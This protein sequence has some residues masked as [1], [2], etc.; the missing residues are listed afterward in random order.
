MSSKKKVTALFDDI[1][2]N[3]LQFF[4]GWDTSVPHEG[5][6]GGIRERRVRD[7][8]ACHLPDKYGIGSGHIVDKKGTMSLQ[9]DIVIFDRINGPV[10]R[11]D[12]YYQVFPCESVCATVEVKST[13]TSGEIEKCIEH[14][15]RLE[16]LDRIDHRGDLG[17]IQSFVF[18]YDSYDNA[19]KAPSVW[20]RDKFQEIASSGPTPRPVPRAIL[21]LR[22]HFVLR[23]DV[24]GL[25][26]FS[27]ESGALLY[28]FDTLLHWLSLVKTAPPLLFT[29]YGWTLGSMTEYDAGGIAI[30]IKGIM[31]GKHSKG[32]RGT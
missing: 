16:E 27:F 7:F 32:G 15:R 24:F 4:E 20:A 2:A 17:P 18:A 8:L 13:L 9:E 5:E 30:P 22:K 3:M 12:S 6:K 23:H 21:C 19:E 29:H 28:F 25:K 26:A 14:T 31:V 10:L 11:I 1:A